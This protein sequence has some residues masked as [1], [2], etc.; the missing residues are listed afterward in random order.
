MGKEGT[1]PASSWCESAKTGKTSAKMA[2]WWVRK[3]MFPNGIATKERQL[4][5]RFRCNKMFAKG[6]HS[7]DV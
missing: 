4:G 1:V 2:Y 5:S 7:S 6:R 3:Q